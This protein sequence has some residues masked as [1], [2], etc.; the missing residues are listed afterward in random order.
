MT[1]QQLKSG[2]LLGTTKLK[3][4]CG[5]TK[6]PE[7]IFTLSDSLEILDL[8]GNQLSEL[9]P[10]FARLHK[11]KIAFFSDNNFTTFPEV[12]SQCPHL[13]MI[14]FKANHINYIAENAISANIRWLILTNNTIA[15]IP[16]S[17]GNCHKLK[18]LML[19]GNQL[20]SLPDEIINCREL[21]LL[22]ISANQ[23]TDFPTHLFE[24]PQLAWLAFAGNP[25]QNGSV[26]IQHQPIEIPWQALKIK[27]TL[28][29]GA[30]GVISKAVLTEKAVREVAV[31]V[32]KGE[33]TS[34][35]LPSDEMNAFIAARKHKNLVA[36]IGKVA[37]HPEN[38][39]ALV[40]ELI[41]STYKNLANPPS[42]DTCTRDV[43]GDNVYLTANQAF[44]IAKGMASAVAHLH[45]LGILHGDL[46]AHN[47][48][49]DEEGNPLF[50]DFG[51]AM[52]YD[53]HSPFA[54]QFEKL[55]VRAFGYLLDDLLNRVKD[56]NK[57]TTMERLLQLK[58]DLLLTLLSQRPDFNAIAEMLE[59]F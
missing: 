53:K 14:G 56:I 18:K 24:L 25:W 34:D 43:F 9:P 45:T 41:N 46:Y 52:V 19:A 23:F 16:K 1:L 36:V 21:Q 13:D 47:I 55:E 39:Q 27:E 20:S 49:I 17:I 2:E 31:K 37:S 12:L 8:S 7:E 11:L 15:T 40:M 58:D 54:K 6:F 32:F 28:G 5:L 50:G 4:S 38:K 48:L 33:V 57:D 35:G 30:S 10:D 3:L 42:F 44:N 29:E 26:N 22:R 59:A 51:A